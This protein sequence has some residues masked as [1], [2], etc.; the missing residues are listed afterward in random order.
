MSHHY[1]GK[2][3]VVDFFI[4]RQGL[5]LGVKT[6]DTHQWCKTKNTKKSTQ[7]TLNLTITTKQRKTS[8]APLTGQRTPGAGC[9]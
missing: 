9:Y 7:Q 5:I 1:D 4:G 6:C 8:Q 2:Q 3:T